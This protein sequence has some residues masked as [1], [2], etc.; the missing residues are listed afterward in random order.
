MSTAEA[1]KPEAR[2]LT[3]AIY[4]SLLT[5][6][7]IAVMWRAEVL[8][9]H[10]GL[11]LV[12]SVV[13]F[14]LTHVSSGIVNLRVRGPVERPALARIGADE[15]PLLWAA[16]V[17]AIVLVVGATGPSDS[18]SRSSSHCSSASSNCSCGGSPSA[19]RPTRAGRSP[20]GWPSS[21][22]PWGSR[23]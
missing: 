5:T 19:E 1:P 16:I 22:A 7:L 23:S 18:T 8:A 14:W 21:T 6:T 17:P 9:A 4:G 13:V 2:D 3:P 11:A 10:I 20:C 15:A 12:G